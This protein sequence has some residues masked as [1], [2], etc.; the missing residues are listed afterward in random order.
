VIFRGHPP[1]EREPQPAAAFPCCPAAPGALRPRRQRIPAFARRLTF[2]AT[3]ADSFTAH[4]PTLQLQV[5]H[6]QGRTSRQKDPAAPGGQTTQTAI[7]APEPH[8]RSAAPHGT[9]ANHLQPPQPSARAQA[10]RRLHTDTPLAGSRAAVTGIPADSVFRVQANCGSVLTRRSTRSERHRQVTRAGRRAWPGSSDEE[11]SCGTRCR[12][13]CRALS[14]S[15]PA[16]DR[17]SNSAGL[18]SVQVTAGSATP[19]TT[20]VDVN[21]DRLPP[22]FP[23]IGVAAHPTQ[24]HRRHRT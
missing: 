7:A 12:P 23:A 16:Q 8:P 13:G 20:P 22:A 18:D 1:V 14:T 2:Q 19:Y 6:I 15:A 3:P 10:H 4:R 11:A 21:Q 5:W 17:A 9:P 24:S